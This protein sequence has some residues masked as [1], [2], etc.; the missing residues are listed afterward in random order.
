MP[1]IWVAVGGRKDLTASMVGTFVILF[2][3][4]TVTIYSQ[5]FALILIGVL[6]LVTVLFAPNGYVIA[7]AGLLSRLTGAGRRPARREDLSREA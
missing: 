2:A 7:L 1:L 6:L 5:Q 4:Q 3:F